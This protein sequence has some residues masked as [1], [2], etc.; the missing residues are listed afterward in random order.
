VD[1]LHVGWRVVGFLSSYPSTRNLSNYIEHLDVLAIDDY[2]YTVRRL[3][4]CEYNL[5]YVLLGGGYTNRKS[6]V[7]QK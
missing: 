1:F 6:V 4:M 2:T 3:L 7:R 5:Y